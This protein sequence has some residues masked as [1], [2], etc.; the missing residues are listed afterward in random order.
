MQN[1]K[2]NRNAKPKSHRLKTKTDAYQQPTTATSSEGHFQYETPYESKSSITLSFAS[3]Y[4][5]YKLKT[6]R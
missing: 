1:A 4:P 6:Y 2:I 5:V 3:K